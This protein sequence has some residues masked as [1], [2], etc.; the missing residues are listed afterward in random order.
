[1][2]EYPYIKLYNIS[3]LGYTSTLFPILLIRTTSHLFQ[4]VDFVGLVHRSYQQKARSPVLENI[5][6]I[7]PSI[8]YYSHVGGRVLSV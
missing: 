3:N 7:I 8:I 1:M 6:I 5:L 4:Q 2:Y